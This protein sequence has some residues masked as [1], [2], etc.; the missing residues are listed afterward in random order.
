MKK[1]KDDISRWRDIPS[2][3]E[4]RISIA[5]MTISPNAIYRFNAIPIK[6]PIAFFT[7]LE[8]KIWQFIWKHKDPE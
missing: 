4:G 5:K 6:L 7:E 8:Q 2:S 1:I 3:W